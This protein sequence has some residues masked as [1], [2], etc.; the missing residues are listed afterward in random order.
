MKWS[1]IYPGV[2]VYHNMF[3][4]WGPG[5]VKSVNTS[6]GR[7]FALVDFEF[8]E[9]MATSRATEIRMTPNRKKIKAMVKIYAAMG[10]DAKDGGDRLI[11]PEGYGK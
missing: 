11:L 7:K 3:T 4:H 10:I 6:Y 1:D 5:V 2:T 8:D 9:G